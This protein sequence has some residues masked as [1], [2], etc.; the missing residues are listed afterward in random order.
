MNKSFICAT[1]WFFYAGENKE[2]AKK[3]INVF[4]FEGLQSFAIICNLVTEHAFK[5]ISISSAKLISVQF[6][7]EILVWRTVART[8]VHRMIM[9]FFGK[10]RS[11]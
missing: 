2:T 4:Q 8:F 6:G 5:A 1:R 11:E 10:L 9:V 7:S 3:N